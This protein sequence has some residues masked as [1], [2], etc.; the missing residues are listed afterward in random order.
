MEK[1]T[2]NR[3]KHSVGVRLIVERERRAVEHSP[4]WCLRLGLYWFCILLCR[5][6]DPDAYYADRVVNWTGILFAYDRNKTA[7]EGQ[8]IWRKHKTWGSHA[9]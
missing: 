2:I 1:E 5:R 8:L 4:S 3:L 6:W 7:K 9:A